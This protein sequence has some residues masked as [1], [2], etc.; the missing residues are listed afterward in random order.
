M[1]VQLLAQNKAEESL[2]KF[3]ENYPQ[4]KVHLLFNKDHYVAGENIWFKAFVFDGYNRSKI[5]T[6]LFVELYDKNKKLVDKK[7]LP[8]LKGEGSG[9][10][11]LAATLDEDVY[12]VRAYTTWMTNFSDDFNYLQPIA[13]YNPSSKQKL[14]ENIGAPWTATIH[15]ESGSFIEG[16]ETKFAVRLK[17]E[18]VLPLNWSGFVSDTARPEEAI[19]TFKSLDQNVG[20][21]IL[22]PEINRQYQLTIVDNAG[23][24]KTF[25]LPTSI[26]YGLT[27]Q[28][29]S[30]DQSVKYTLKSKNIP[31][32]SQP[33]KILGT[34]NNTLVYKAIINQVSEEQS[35]SISTDKLING[36]LRLS[37]FDN[38]EKVIAERLCFVRPQTLD[39]RRPNIITDFS[40]KEKSLNT[41]TIKKDTNL[42]NY[43]VTVLDAESSSSEEENNLLS[44]L[45]LTG[46][47]RS[48]IDKPSQYFIANRNLQALDALLISE[49]WKRFEWNSIISGSYPLIKN[50]PESYI[51]YKGKVLS[52]NKPAANSDLNLIFK[53]P[54]SGLKLNTVKTD[55]SGFFTLDNLVFED[56]LAFSYQLNSSKKAVANNVQVYFQP[57]FSFIPLRKDLPS[58]NLKLTDNV[59][60]DQLPKKIA[61]SVSTITFEKFVNE[62][63]MD[64]E[65]VKIKVDRKNKTA[66]L[67]NELSSPL[68]K[69][70][71]EMIFDFVNENNIL[72][73]NNILLWLQ[74]RV[75]GLRI[76]SQGANTT[77]TMRGGNVQLYLD[78]MR[79][80]ASQILTLSLADVAM[81]KVI[82]ESFAGGIGGGGNGAIVIYTKRGGTSGFAPDAKHSSLREM[83]LKGYDKTE[84]FNNKIYES[85][86]QQGLTKD[87]RSTLYWNPN[88]TKDEAEKMKVEFYNN[89]EAKDY[90][91]I[92]IGFDQQDTPLY[93]NEVLK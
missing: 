62:K 17:S 52:Q 51:S 53:M 31:K 47:L 25:N 59:Q 86:E 79:T 40:S 13:V 27:L 8:L 68:F 4:E 77:A 74:G 6:S 84:P 70:A 21:F 80:D 63:I 28:V 38:E 33:Y 10:F 54:D 19:V 30:N 24:K 58:S 5:S 36:I 75:P 37:V 14:T 66:K 78:E 9:S 85:I 43:S 2:K 76:S 64:I 56:T 57:A 1:P 44:T 23:A 72:G 82:R 12:F 60:T 7:M 39:I 73:N 87:T 61:K 50:K 81:I 67:N 69:S 16:I 71:N 45:W 20:S 42:D 92:I 83:N 18:G 32:G 49:K 26:T 93:F 48:K 55:N 41:F 91:V 29:E 34:I 11:S 35:A 89:D 88:L 3:A 15:P 46:D 90:K 65:E 22:K